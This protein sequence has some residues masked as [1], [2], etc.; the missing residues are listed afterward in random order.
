MHLDYF[1]FSLPFDGDLWGGL[2]QHEAFQFK[3]KTKTVMNSRYKM[4]YRM[5]CGAIYSIPKDGDWKQKRLIEMKGQE[6]KKAREMKLTDD[7]L[8]TLTLMG[9]GSISRMDCAFDTDNPLAKVSDVWE[10][11]QN[12]E[13]KT[14]IRQASL[15]STAGRKGEPANSVYFGATDSDQRIIVYDKA[16]QLKLLNQA[17][18]RV[19]LRLYGNAAYRAAKDS[20]V[21]SIDTVA[22][23]KVRKMVK[24]KIGW[25]EKMM[26]GQDVELTPLKYD[27]DTLRWLKTQVAP[28]ID[29]LPDTQPEIVGEVVNWL[30]GRLN[31]LL[32]GWN[33]FK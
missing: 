18:V 8:I 13:I 33:E 12:N 24:T 31:I 1:T 10:A 16:K 15:M 4:S 7:N 14:K 20:L 3:L 22:R 25:F 23:Q 28:A 29:A 5:A 19:E 27:S 26:E 17:W 32:P 2:P 30:Y 6:L 11:W 9:G 21:H